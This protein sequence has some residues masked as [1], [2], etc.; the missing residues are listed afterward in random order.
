MSSKKPD[1][2]LDKESSRS[3]ILDLGIGSLLFEQ[4][5]DCIAE[6]VPEPTTEETDSPLNSSFKEL[7][8]RHD[9]SSIIKL[10][11]ANLKNSHNESLASEL[12]LDS[13]SWWILAQLKLKEFPILA[14]QGPMD[15]LVEIS[16][17]LQQAQKP[18]AQSFILAYL[19]FLENLLR[20]GNFQ[21]SL[22][23]VRNSFALLRIESLNTEVKNLCENL[24]L[25][26]R[27]LNED[28]LLIAKELRKLLHLENKKADVPIPVAALTAQQPH[29]TKIPQFEAVNRKSKLSYIF[30]YTVVILILISTLSFLLPY[31]SGPRQS[32]VTL[33]KSKIESPKFDIQIPEPKSIEQISELDLIMYEVDKKLRPNEIPASF[34]A[35]EIREIQQ[36]TKSETEILN[37]L[38]PKEKA[39]IDTSG[40]K[41]DSALR[42]LRT[43]KPKLRP[44]PEAIAIP[45][46]AIA[47]NFTEF[48]SLMLYQVIRATSLMS[49]PS[50][51]SEA[52]AGLSKGDLVQVQGQQGYWYRLISKQGKVAYVLSDDVQPTY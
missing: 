51:K 8:D 20:Q 6:K 19:S 40:P 45:G 3:A 34:A 27:H 13:Q 21:A 36:P 32:L 17:K 29:F 49:G 7:F 43:A 12:W 46:P 15:S 47:P 2:N 41:E 9:Y 5:S 33:L 18:I 10:A 52:V 48:P 11:E 26:L 23:L 25:N 28:N 35:Q 50:L 39:R 44:E 37:K 22:E 24:F 1:S 31:L 16:T 38:P 42:A 4:S 30:R 14:L